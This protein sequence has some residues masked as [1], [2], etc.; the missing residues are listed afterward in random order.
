MAG[1][2]TDSLLVVPREQAAAASMSRTALRMPG[3]YTILADDPYR[4]PRSMI[5]RFSASSRRGLQTPRTT[6]MT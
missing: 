4:P 2:L 6:T 5:S 1:L 3:T